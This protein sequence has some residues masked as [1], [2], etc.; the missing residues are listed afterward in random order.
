MGAEKLSLRNLLRAIAMSLALFLVVSVYGR[1]SSELRYFDGP[2]H[3]LDTCVSISLASTE[4]D[5]RVEARVALQGLKERAGFSRERWR[6]CLDGNEEDSIVMTLRW[7]NTDF[8]SLTDERIVRLDV[9]RGDSSIFSARLDG[10]ATAPGVFNTLAATLTDSGS[11]L[12]LSGGSDADSHIATLRLPRPFRAD[13]ARLG[14]CG[15]AELAVF[16]AEVEAPSP[17][18]HPD[19]W[20]IESLKDHFASTSD[21]VEGFW[22]HLDRE[23]NPAYARPGGTYTLA[24]VKTEAGTYDILYI[25]GARILADKWKPCMLKGSLVPT[26][27]VGQYTLM[28]IDSEFEPITEDLSADLTDNSVLALRFP[29]YE[30]VIRLS[31]KR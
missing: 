6:L 17:F 31:K 4:P 27:F 5:C 23:N 29:L 14:I 16:A 1:G 22:T 11:S 10:F 26:I 18:E 24:V 13:S 25:S 9:E 8:G 21:P 7:G 2:A 15:R 12:R 3:L 19:G 28:W 30:T 20:T